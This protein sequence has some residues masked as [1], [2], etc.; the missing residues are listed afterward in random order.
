MDYLTAIPYFTNNVTEIPRTEESS[1]MTQ[2]CRHR[3][4]DS[5]SGAFRKG[6]WRLESERGFPR[7]PFIYFV[8]TGVSFCFFTR[9]IRKMLS[10][11]RKRE[12]FNNALNRVLWEF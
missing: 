11:F 8:T 10:I 7:L 12:H 2:Q 3:A 9:F 5:Q 1:Q 6:L 4:P